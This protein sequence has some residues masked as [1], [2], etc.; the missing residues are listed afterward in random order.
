MRCLHCNS[1]TRFMKFREFWNMMW[2]DK[3]SGCLSLF[4]LLTCPVIFTFF[5]AAFAFIRECDS[6]D[7][8]S[9]NLFGLWKKY[10][11]AS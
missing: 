2:E 5:V 4:V 8:V 3:V 10:F 9:V 7:G 1:P 6:C 11:P